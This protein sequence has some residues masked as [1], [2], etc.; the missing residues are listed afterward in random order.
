MTLEISKII[1]RLELIKNLISLEEEESILEQTNKLEEFQSN[2][3][4]K[5][6]TLLLK[7]KSYGKAIKQIEIFMISYQQI[8]IYLDPEIDALKFEIKA[9]EGE[10]NALSD[11]K[12]DLEKLIHEFGI[13]HN[14]ELGTLIIK[15]LKSRVEK[16]KGTIQNREA[17]EDYNNY[18]KE[19]AASK[20]EEIASI[21]EEEKKELKDK[22]R[23]ASKLCHPDVVSEEQ[24]E[25]ATKIFSELTSAYEN[26]NIKLVREI[27]GNLEN[28]NFFI[29][30]SE[31]IN[32]KKLL[33]TEIE[34]QRLRVKELKEQI[35][36][37]M[38][39]ETYITII[40]IN[41]WDEYFTNTKQKLSS[42]I[43]ELGSGN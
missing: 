27:L 9:L 19:Y 39:S 12:A 22:Y 41:N 10:I 17:E 8:S 28:G 40:N 31:A 1:K 6:I 29:N 35:L 26:N 7:Q 37:I 32:E 18:H 43:N 15:I 16:T 36:D 5:I 30:K 25:L 2:E 14:N 13:R 21:T 20:N 38:R 33:Q 34:K 42:Q 3:E 4:V 23:K 11:Q 24:K